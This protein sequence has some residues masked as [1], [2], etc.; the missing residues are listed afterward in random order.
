MSS[1]F[2]FLNK[3]TGNSGSTG[4]ESSHNNDTNGLK[5]PCVFPHQEI[6][7]VTSGN[8]EVK[9]SFL[10]PAIP[11]KKEPLGTVEPNARGIVPAVTSV[12]T[13]NDKDINYLYHERAGILQYDGGFPQAEAERL[14][15]QEIL[16]IY[17]EGMH[18]TIIETFQNIILNNSGE[19]T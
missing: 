6:S 18:P 3:S 19:K 15:Y 8:L 1:Y 4:N 14:A 12:P 11:R 17:V 5:G 10:L 13:Q 9:K 2:D 16:L 7:L